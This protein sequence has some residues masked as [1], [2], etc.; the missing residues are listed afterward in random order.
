MEFGTKDRPTP[1]CPDPTWARPLWST[2]YRVKPKKAH[3]CASSA[4][5]AIRFVRLLHHFK[6]A[7]AGQPFELLPYQEWEIFRPL[8]GWKVEACE[9][10]PFNIPCTAARLYRGL[11]LETPKKMGKTQV[12]A[13]IAGYMSFAD[14]EPGAETYT[15]AADKEQAKIAFDALSFGISYKGSPFEAKGIIPLKTS[16]TNQRTRSFVKVQTSSA[17]TKHGPNAHCIIFDELH[18]QKNREL[19]DVVVPGVANRRQPLVAALTTAGWDRNSICFEQREY[20]RQISEEV[21]DDSSFLGIIYSLPEDA[22]WTQKENWYKAAP[23]LG[24][25]VQEEYY[26]RKVTEAKQ[27]PSAQNSFRQL[28]CSQ[29]T[30]QAIRIIPL[31]AWDRNDGKPDLENLKKTKARCY[32]GL[33]LSST[34]DLSAL[35]LVFPG[36]TDN[37]PVDVLLKYWMPA[38][39]LRARSLRDR[40]P[41][42]RWVDEGLITATPGNVV[43]Y[44]FIKSEI[45]AAKDSYNLQEISYDPWNATQM[46]LELEK[47]RVKLSP[48]RQGFVSMSPPLKELLRMILQDK[49]RHG[50]N[51]VLRWNA[52]SCAGVTDA[53]ENIKLDK[54]KSTARIDGMVATVMALDALLRHPNSRRKSVYED[55]DVTI[56]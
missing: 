38:D 52:D 19:W 55:E 31:E 56:G 43:D 14:N 40:V 17:A 49:L 4:E 27:M 29:W 28:H 25:T 33:D 41:Y 21:F 36:P 51:P 11:Y 47:S 16:I 2:A 20:A 22:D 42:E 37:D 13:A 3:Y 35:A 53:A 9:P 24:V 39:N 26:E 18:A 34:T 44:D 15:Y 10:H 54:S 23:S 1:D 6:G 7:F 5:R 12:G 30:Q 46:I 45:F 48:M 32:G 8:F 50:G